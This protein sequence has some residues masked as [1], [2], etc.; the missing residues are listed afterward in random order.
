LVIVRRHTPIDPPRY[1]LC[2]A[3]AGGLA[4]L[5]TAPVLVATQTQLRVLVLNADG[6]WLG[7]ALLVI[8]FGLIF[9]PAAAG[10]AIMM[11]GRE[12]E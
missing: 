11:L 2:H 3:L 5:V 8:G 10:H 9:A 1:I 4:G 7:F 12:E 6:G